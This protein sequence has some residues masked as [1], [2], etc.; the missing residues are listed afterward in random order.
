MK[1]PVFNRRSRLGLLE[2]LFNQGVR[3]NKFEIPFEILTRF[4]SDFLKA[5]K[6]NIFENLFTSLKSDTSRYEA[7]LYLILKALPLMT[8]STSAKFM[9]TIE[10]VLGVE[11]SESFW[12]K[13]LNPLRVGL[14]LYRVMSEVKEIHNY[15]SNS[16]DL[17]K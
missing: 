7:K 3:Q 4:M 11:G 15:S 1:R 13:N 12:M 17:M 9:K 10:S 5:H 6:V 16:T 8:K 2:A 14:L